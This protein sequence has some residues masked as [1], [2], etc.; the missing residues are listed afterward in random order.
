MQS[1]E[2]KGPK[3]VKKPYVLGNFVTNYGGDGA[4]T[5]TPN[6]PSSPYTAVVGATTISGTT[7]AGGIVGSA[8]PG[9]NVNING[10]GATDVS[11]V[12]AADPLLTLSD[13]ETTYVDLWVNAT[14]SGACTI[15]LQGSNNR[16]QGNTDYNSSAWATLLTTTITGNGVTGQSITMNNTASGVENP[17]MAYRITASGATA[18]GIIDWA[19]PGFFVDYSAMG[20]GNNAGDANGSIGQLNIQGPRYLTISGGNITNTVNGTPPY[21]ATS[22]NIDYYG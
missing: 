13:I 11:Y 21:S 1:A 9:L 4:P 7:W 6:P 20:I 16:F 14:F 2:G 18:S 3:Q 12:C 19:L 15:R 8:V 10:N 5:G 17:K 22:N